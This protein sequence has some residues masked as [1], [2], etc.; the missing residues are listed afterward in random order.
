MFSF[1]YLIN[2]LLF[3]LLSVSGVEL[4]W[5]RRSKLIFEDYLVALTSGVAGAHPPTG[6]GIRENKQK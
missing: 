5:R 2:L 3:V 4:T 6:L 1:I